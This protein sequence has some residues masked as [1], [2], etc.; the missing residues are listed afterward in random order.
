[1]AQI[2]G[3]WRGAAVALTLGMSAAGHTEEPRENSG[4]P[5]SSPGDTLNEVV[6]EQELTLQA[7]TASSHQLRLPILELKGSITETGF[8]QNV[9]YERMTFDQA[10]LDKLPT[11]KKILAP[12]FLTIS[13]F[14]QSNLVKEA[15]RELETA[16]GAVAEDSAERPLNFLA[17]K[18]GALNRFY[19]NLLKLD[20]DV[21]GKAFDVLLSIGRALDSDNRALDLS[22]SRGSLKDV[23][24]W[25]DVLAKGISPDS[26]VCL[27]QDEKGVTAIEHLHRLLESDPSPQA[28]LL[29]IDILLDLDSPHTAGFQTSY[30]HCPSGGIHNFVLQHLPGE[31][32]RQV[33]ELYLNG[34]TQFTTGKICVLDSE[35]MK[36]EHL[37]RRSSS[38]TIFQS[39]LM[40]YG[41]ENS[42]RRTQHGLQQGL[43]T[44]EVRHLAC[45]Y[46]GRDY[47]WA[48]G[49]S[50]AA[51]LLKHEPSSPV[52]GVFANFEGAGQHVGHFVWF[53]HVKEDRLHFRDSN[54]NYALHPHDWSIL[55]AQNGETPKWH[56]GG[57]TDAGENPL[58][59]DIIPMLIQTRGEKFEIWFSGSPGDIP[60]PGFVRHNPERRMETWN[61]GEFSIDRKE[62]EKENPM[63]LV[64]MDLIQKHFKPVPSPTFSVRGIIKGVSAGLVALSAFWLAAASYLRGRGKSEPVAAPQKD[65]E[66]PLG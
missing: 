4:A 23:M 31:Y 5:I 60:A 64:P 28:V 35:A 9:H 61:S 22:T 63:F 58:P 34:K 25:M 44:E 8:T 21:Q 10:L 32:V 66:Q 2:T 38:G 56:W 20:H 42:A 59:A 48:H 54:G 55:R 18:I 16:G 37:V 40:K 14:E 11:Y 19:D 36:E 3:S 50:A 17:G 29:A 43:D 49:P 24:G 47:Q 46:F 30:P 65:D 52:F 62:L 33:S 26:G 41:A 53:T 45:D 51:L 6:R 12:E 7:P 15:V 39:S 13:F 57:C 1:M 27:V